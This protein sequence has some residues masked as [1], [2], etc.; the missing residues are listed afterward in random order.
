MHQLKIQIPIISL[1][2]LAFAPS[3]SSQPVI[4]YNPV[5]SSLSNPVEI[6]S[7]NDDSHRLFIVQKGGVIKVYNAFYN[8][9]GDFLSVTGIT[10]QGERGLLSLAFHPVYKSNGLFF[11]YYTNARGDIEIASYQVSS[12]PDIADPSSKKIIIAIPHPGAAN[13]NGGKLAFGPDGYLYFATGDGGGSGDRSNNAQNGNSLL[14]KMIRIDIN[15]V[16]PPLNY[17]IPA[18]NPFV[19]DAAVADEIWAL[20]LRNPWRWSF[21]RLTG[22]MWIADVGQNARE[23]INFARAGENKALN[24]GWRCYEGN[25]PYNTNN[26]QAIDQYTAPIFDY[27]H[28][29]TDGGYSV[30]GGFVYRGAEYPALNGYYVFADYV[31]GNQWVIKDSSNEW[32]T[33]KLTGNLPLNVSGFGE[34]QDGSLYACSLSSGIVYKLEAIT[35]VVFQVLTFTG[36]VRNNIVELSWSMVE[37]SLKQY[38]VER[39]TDSLNFEQVG[40]V[41]AQNL[42]TVNN[43]RFEDQV[44]TPKVFYRLRIINNDDKW[45]YSNTIA[46]TNHHSDE[47]FIYPSLITNQIISCFI[48]GAFDQL[49]VFSMSGALVINKD[50]RGIAGRIDIPVANLAKGLYT[51]RIIRGSERKIQR[52]FIR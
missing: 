46:V 38:E 27:P 34:A 22:D 25:R 16:S 20:G 31:S 52:I 26:C 28:N 35:S 33:K 5:I 18:D 11:V 4:Q 6:V 39:S 10:T 21:D 8:Y 37:Q 9:L 42:A 29:N 43:Y 30:T 1:C 45:D 13:H 17:S 49:Q 2:L 40:V 14:G 3:L 48:P 19:N 24:Y 7:A 23:E 47:L 36:I 32:L 50:I 51:V 12:D 15:N 44:T 41:E